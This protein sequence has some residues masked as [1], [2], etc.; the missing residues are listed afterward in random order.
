MQKH[1]GQRTPKHEIIYFI[2]KVKNYNNAGS[3]NGW[4][5]RHMLLLA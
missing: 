5:H 3:E 1:C 2:Q 4:I